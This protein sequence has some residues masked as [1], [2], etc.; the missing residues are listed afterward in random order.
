MNN[1]T[2]KKF[3]QT[4]WFMWLTLVLFAPIGILLLWTR[5][6][7]TFSNKTKGI[8]SGVFTVFF[9]FILITGGQDAPEIADNNPSIVQHENDTTKETNDPEETEEVSASEPEKETP[10][11]P[12]ELFTAAVNNLKDVTYDLNEEVKDL[13]L[14]F[15]LSG[16]FTN[17]GIIDGFYIDIE[18]VCRALKDNSLLD[19]YDNIRFV[20]KTMFKNQYGEESEQPAMSGVIKVEDINRIIYENI[21]YKDI[22]NVVET[23][24]IHPALRK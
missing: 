7:V 4:N 17:Q 9:I 11:T 15:T 14:E 21:S 23:E 16:G 2:G 5:K 24:M 12:E 13:R 10:K 22:E 20:A 8:L 6:D 19:K 3:Y 1:G 18:K